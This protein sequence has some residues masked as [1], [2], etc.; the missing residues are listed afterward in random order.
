MF[1]TAWRRRRHFQLES[2]VRWSDG[3]SLA[4]QSIF[5]VAA[6][7]E[8]VLVPTVPGSNGLILDLPDDD[9]GV[10]TQDSAECACGQHV[11]ILGTAVTAESCGPVLHL[12]RIMHWSPPVSTGCAYLLYHPLHF[13]EIAGFSQRQNY[14]EISL[15]S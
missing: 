14:L 12:H 9:V 8:A 15:Y 4:P 2:E 11:F 13:P 5:G 10:G 6:L 1:G 7:L 3:H